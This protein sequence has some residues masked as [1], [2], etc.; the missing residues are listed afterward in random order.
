IYYG[1]HVIQFMKDFGFAILSGVAGLCVVGLTIY[2]YR[3]RRGGNPPGVKEASA[4]TGDAA[5]GD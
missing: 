2:F 3:S 1:E 5:G 4:T